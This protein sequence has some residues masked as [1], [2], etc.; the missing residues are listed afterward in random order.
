MKKAHVFYVV[1]SE[2]SRVLLIINPETN[3][4]TAIDAI[5]QKIVEIEHFD[6][7]DLT[8]EEL[9][10][11]GLMSRQELRDIAQD[12]WDNHETYYIDRRWDATYAVDIDVD[13]L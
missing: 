10:L 2:E 13:I 1:N 6:Y 4:D 5:Y 9:E 3:R 11:E 8:D 7:E 12:I